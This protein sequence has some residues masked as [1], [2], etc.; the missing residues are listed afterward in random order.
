MPDI[1]YFNGRCYF[2]RTIHIYGFMVAWLSISRVSLKMRFNISS[3]Y[4]ADDAAEMRF[5]TGMML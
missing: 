3:F 5:T 2:C 1:A 4:F